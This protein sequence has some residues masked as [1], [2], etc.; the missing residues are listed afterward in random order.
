MDSSSSFISSTPPAYLI[1]EAIIHD[2]TK[3]SKYCEVV[4]GLISKYGGEY[5]VLGGNHIPLE[6]DWGPTRLVI[7][8]WPSSDAAKKFW[9]SEEYSLAKPLREGTG[10]FKVMLVEG[11]TQQ[12]IVLE[13]SSPGEK[14]EDEMQNND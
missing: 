13:S 11:M 6:G 4:P 2:R 8:R 9:N 1:V 12:Q 14:K 3:F 7:S 10:E 5:I